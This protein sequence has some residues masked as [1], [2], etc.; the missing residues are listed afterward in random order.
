MVGSFPNAA[1]VKEY[2]INNL[3]SRGPILTKLLTSQLAIHHRIARATGQGPS[4][5]GRT[6]LFV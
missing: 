3:L 2:A 6:A 1:L 5:D 4:L